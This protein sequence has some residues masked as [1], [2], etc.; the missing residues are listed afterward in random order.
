[1]SM[2]TDG[3]Y[4]RQVPVVAQEWLAAEVEHNQ[5]VG[6]LLRTSESMAYRPGT[7]DS[8]AYRPN[9]AE[10]RLS[11]AGSIGLGPYEDGLVELNHRQTRTVSYNGKA[12]PPPE[13]FTEE[14]ITY[15]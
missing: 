11:T 9:T 8:M 2:T 3:R 1:M 13:L 6:L 5:L 7:S 14:E 15:M 4:S 12:H 10:G